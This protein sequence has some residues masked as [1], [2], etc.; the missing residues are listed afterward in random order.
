MRFIMLSV[1]LSLT[2][3]FCS[4]ASPR[5]DALSRLAGIAE[6]K[7]GA[8][9]AVSRL[10]GQVRLTRSCEEFIEEVGLF[11]NRVY[12]KLD[13]RDRQDKADELKSQIDEKN[14]WLE[15]MVNNIPSKDELGSWFS[16]ERGQDP[17]TDTYMLEI[18]RLESEISSLNGQFGILSLGVIFEGGTEVLDGSLWLG[19]GD[20][21]MGAEAAETV[22]TRLDFY[23]D[24][25]E[26]LEEEEKKV[27]KE[28]EPEKDKK[29]SVPQKKD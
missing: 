27:Q 9:Q 26:K 5:E 23:N 18:Q 24:L 11:D 12:G 8:K 6:K 28:L 3:A 10:E 4:E 29:E 20:R 15:W 19:E 7:A 21:L 1:Y 25:L 13:S 17:F 2:I 16:E 22:E 14:E